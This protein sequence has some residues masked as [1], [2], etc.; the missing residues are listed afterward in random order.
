ML[1]KYSI[2]VNTIM[3]RLIIKKNNTIRK[4]IN[5]GSFLSS[6]LFTFILLTGFLIIKQQLK[7]E[8]G[9]KIFYFS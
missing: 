9:A 8:Q 6:N 3:G 5:T 4:T 2:Y 7:T 1:S